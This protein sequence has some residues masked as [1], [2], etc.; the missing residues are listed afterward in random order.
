MS[1]INVTRP[2][3]SYA[4]LMNW[5]RRGERLLLVS[6]APVTVIRPGWF[7]PS[8]ATPGHPVL[9]QGDT[10][11]YG[12]VAVKHVAEALIAAL[13]H[14]G[15]TAEL[16]TEPGAATLDWARAFGAITPDQAR[17]LDCAA[18]PGSLPEH[19]EPD[20]VRADLA[21]ARTLYLPPTPRTENHRD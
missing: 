20:H 19:Q 7:E 18:D 21:W 13:Q 10:V 15:H 9:K 14:P 11:Q 5:K 1:S 8:G 16:F 6:G 12:P 4:E 17:V 2:S 3:G